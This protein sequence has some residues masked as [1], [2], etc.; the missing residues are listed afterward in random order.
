VVAEL[1]VLAHALADPPAADDEQ[2][3]GAPTLPRA[4][5]EN[6]ICVVRHV[7]CDRQRLE[8]IAVDPEFETGGQADIKEEQALRLPADVTCPAG[9]GKSRTVDGGDEPAL[10]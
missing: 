8:G 9:Q 6:K 3:V 5:A 2:V 7:T 4:L 1:D 10:V